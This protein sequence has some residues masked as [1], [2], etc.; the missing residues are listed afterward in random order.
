MITLRIDGLEE[1]KAGLSKSPDII[2]SE[3][4]QAM[5]YSVGAVEQEAHQL[6]PFITGTLRRSIHT[7]VNNGGFQ[8]IVYQSNAE[9]PYGLYVEYGTQPHEILPINKQALFWK[10]ALNPYKRVMHPGTKANP[11]MEQ[12]FGNNID[13]IQG[14]FQT[15]VDNLFKQI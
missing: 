12:A 4:K 11:F 6:A 5:V 10:G 8:G 14:Y 7:A 13:A 2:R 15:A 9:A 1:L 3:V